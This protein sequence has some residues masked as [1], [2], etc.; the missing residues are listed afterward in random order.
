MT[1]TTPAPT[2]L[3]LDAPVQLTEVFHSVQGEGVHVGLPTTFVRFTGCS[4]RCAWCDTTY[5]FYGGDAT[6]VGAIVERVKTFLPV[7]RVC[8]T[9]G[10]PL[11]QQDAALALL[12]A[13][14]DDGYE[15]V[16]ETSGGLSIAKA[17]A[18]ARRERLLVS[19]DV[20][21]PGS[22]MQRRNVWENLAFLREHDQLKF[23]LADRRDYDYARDVLAKH[24]PRARNVLF[25]PMWPSP[26]PVTDTRLEG[27]PA[28]LK[29]V[30]EWVLADGLDV[31]V[32]TQLHKLIWGFEK[33]R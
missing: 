17:D 27:E 3:G 18:L 2:A 8:L 31:R 29:N 10:E 7:K 5:S 14:L 12:G 32:G 19:L 23:V 20:K 28:T 33:G 11:D 24:A 25:Q 9:G 26:N 6:T 13:L 1:A 15:C 4:L 21:C 22:N 16:L 30:A